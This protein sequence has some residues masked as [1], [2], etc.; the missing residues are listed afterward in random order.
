MDIKAFTCRVP[1]CDGPRSGVCINSLS[2]EDCPD[3]I[4]VEEIGEPAAATEISQAAGGE[5][6]RTGGERNLDAATC[7]ALL[8]AR[9]GVVIGVVAG[10]EVGKTTMIATM[11]ELIHRGRMPEFRFAGSETLRGYE[12]RCHL[13]RLASNAL[14][15][16]TPRTHLKD[17]LSFTHLRL[18][19]ALGIKDVVFSDRSGEHFDNILKTPSEITRFSELQRANTIAMLVDLHELQKSHH[20]PTSQ[21]RRLFIAME[22]A[23]MLAGKKMMLVGTK[24]DLLGNDNG[25]E[26]ARSALT[27]LAGDLQR[28]SSTGLSIT[29]W[30]VAS[31]ARPGSTEV[32]EGLEELLKAMIAGHETPRFS[33]GNAWPSRP[34]ELDALMHIFRSKPQ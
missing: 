5:M 15:P 13:A 20:R 28:R 10:P 29:T 12:E 19:T 30:L 9:G 4:P 26:C 3:V 25:T 17:Q 33:P 24:A 1:G 7:D 8:R 32:G 16:D 14:R 18:K 34:T 2:F 31:R 11:Y 22:Q 23:G 6:V 21:A 27:E